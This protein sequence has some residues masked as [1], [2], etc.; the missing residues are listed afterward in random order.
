MLA[1]G[2]DYRNLLSIS[3]DPDEIVEAIVEFADRHPDP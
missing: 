1:D 3:D 2:K